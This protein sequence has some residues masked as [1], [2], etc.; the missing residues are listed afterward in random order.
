MEECFGELKEWVVEAAP[1]LDDKAR[2][3]LTPATLRRYAVARNGDFDAAVKNITATLE[4][5]KANVPDSMHCTACD[6]DTGMH[7]FSCVGI[8]DHRRV[9][10]YA[11]AAR[12]KTN[13]TAVTVGH[14][15][16]TLEHAWTYTE[17]LDLHHQWL[18]IVDF[19]G[20]GLS[21]AMQ[22]RTSNGALAAFS[23]HMPERL[24]AVLLLNPPRIF[25]LLL[26]AIKPFLDA[27]TMSKVHI[28]RCTAETA[29]EALVPF[30]VKAGSGIS[31]FMSEV[32]AMDAKPG[33]V[34]SFEMLDHEVVARIGLPRWR[35]GVAPARPPPLKKK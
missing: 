1:G 10:V 20:F 3:F 23:E 28:V 11:C 5:R 18:W 30:G 29:A 14:M 2:S 24:G 15:C 13:E 31:R 34:P 26:A 33:N 32:L 4:W 12:A 7:C 19:N 8:D 17:D 21:H 22:G 6:S 25:D 35:D 16:Q 27:R 9:V